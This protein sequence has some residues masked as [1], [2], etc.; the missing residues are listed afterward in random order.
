MRNKKAGLLT[1]FAAVM[2][3]VSCT[4]CSQ[5]VRVEA[6]SLQAISRCVEGCTRMRH[7]E[8]GKIWRRRILHLLL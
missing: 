2:A 4:A 7:W 6:G 8:Q 3:A 1:L 5:R